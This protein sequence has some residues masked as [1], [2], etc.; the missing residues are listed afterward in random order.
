M[1]PCERPPEMYG[2]W[3]KTIGGTSATLEDSWMEARHSWLTWNVEWL[4]WSRSNKGESS[5]A[6]LRLV[7]QCL[8]GLNGT[9]VDKTICVIE[10]NFHLILFISSLCPWTFKNIFKVFF[11]LK[12]LL[13]CWSHHKSTYCIYLRY[14]CLVKYRTYS[15]KL[16]GG[17]QFPYRFVL[18]E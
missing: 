7:S 13:R 16:Q 3:S 12:W 17:S 15:Y 1:A 8:T 5:S 4:C 18:S 9:A 10:A 6:F 2:E 14:I 11:F